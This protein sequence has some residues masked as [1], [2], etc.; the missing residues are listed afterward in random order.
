[1][2]AGKPQKEGGESENELP[3]HAR[4]FSNLVDFH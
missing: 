3:L 1:M 4:D 2:S